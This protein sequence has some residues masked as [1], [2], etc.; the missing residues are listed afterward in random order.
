MKKKLCTIVNAAY[1]F[2]YLRLF[3]L[4]RHDDSEGI[5]CLRWEQ[6]LTPFISCQPADEEEVLLLTF[7]VK[8]LKSIV[9]FHKKIGTYGGGMGN[10]N[11]TSLRSHS[12]VLCQVH[13]DGPRF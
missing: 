13:V 10:G 7:I 12:T 3:I 8:L 5:L 11:L 4:S 1:H 2:S 9:V 6:V